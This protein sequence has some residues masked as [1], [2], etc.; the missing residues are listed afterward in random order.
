MELKLP[1]SIWKLFFAQN[2]QI[3]S[4]LLFQAPGEQPRDD[5]PA[6]SSWRDHD[7]LICQVWSQARS[8]HADCVADT[9]GGWGPGAAVWLVERVQVAWI[10]FSDWSRRLE[11]GVSVGLAARVAAPVHTGGWAV[12]GD[13]VETETEASLPVQLS[14]RVEIACVGVC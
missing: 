4:K 14:T 11:A 10:L 1:Y 2:A 12:T 6:R 13:C 9:R 8:V 7:G 3:L 5:L